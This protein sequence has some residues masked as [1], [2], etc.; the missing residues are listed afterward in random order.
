ME[1]CVVVQA[2][3][4]TVQV[5]DILIFLN[6]TEYSP[7]SIKLKTARNLNQPCRR[8]W[9]LFSLP[10][11]NVVFHMVTDTQ[12]ANKAPLLNLDSCSTD[13]L[14]FWFFISKWVRNQNIWFWWTPNNGGRWELIRRALSGAR[15]QLVVCRSLKS[16]WLSAH[17]GWACPEL[18]FLMAVPLLW[19]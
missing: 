4:K 3:L 6:I 17:K 16:E 5:G 18:E 11:I 10:R 9:R 14:P 7:K 8:P 12:N 19:G 2:R 15:E 13:Y 1:F